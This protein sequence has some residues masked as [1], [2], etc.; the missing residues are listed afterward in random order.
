M[1]FFGKKKIIPVP[2]EPKENP[3]V[4]AS[5]LS[6]ITYSW[7]NPIFKVGFNRPLQKNDLYLLHP[8]FKEEYNEKRFYTH[9]NEMKLT[10]DDKG[11][12]YKALWK[13]FGL[14]Y[15]IAGIHKFVSD[16]ANLLSPVVL[17]MLLVSMIMKTRIEE[18]LMI[19]L[20][21]RVI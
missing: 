21:K 8:R 15:S 11:N 6:K 13:V 7:E 5:L 10:Q 19:S 17:E 20:V 4:K 1:L 9:W 12:V 18:K 2:D 3:Y 16:M 14:E